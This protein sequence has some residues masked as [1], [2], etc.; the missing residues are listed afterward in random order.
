VVGRS[1]SAN[2]PVG[3][4]IK[5]GDDMKAD[6]KYFNHDAVLTDTDIQRRCPVA[7][8]AGNANR[9]SA[10][11]VHVGTDQIIT[12]LRGV[13]WMPVHAEQ[14][15]CRSV[16]RQGFQKHEI[17]FRRQDDMD[18]I[19]PHNIELVL[20]NSHDAGCSYTLSVG[21]WRRIC[22][23]GLVVSGGSFESIRYRHMGLSAG[24]V[25]DGSLKVGEMMPELAD[26]I[27]RFQARE[28]GDGEAAE[29]ARRAVALRWEGNLPVKPDQLLGVRRLDDAGQSVWKV[30][31]RIQE[32]IVHGGMT[33][34]RARVGGGPDR[35]FRV[36]ALRGIDSRLRVNR[37][38]W[39]LADEALEGK[40]N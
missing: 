15:R 30:L 32:N 33:G 10:R 12:G 21:I 11:Y 16:D 37:G 24:D 6:T 31:N 3:N 14:Q 27:E 29:F 4:Q 17:W 40:W 36:Q 39:A 25:V 19:K 35:T 18:S 23:N 2:K 20:D 26:R 7:F 8:Q 34:R 22:S 1:R 28:L 38:L 5:Y 13:G 9:C